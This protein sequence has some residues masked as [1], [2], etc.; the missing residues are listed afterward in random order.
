MKK[1]ILIILFFFIIIQLSYSQTN[2]DSLKLLLNSVNEENKAKILNDIVNEDAEYNTDSCLIY[3]NLALELSEK[4]KIKKEIPEANRQ[5]GRCLIFLQKYDSALIF[6]EKAIDIFKKIDDKEGEANCL[7]NIGR[8]YENKYDYN[9]S[10]N[11]YLEAL[12]IYELLK[13]KESIANVYQDIGYVYIY[14][15]KDELALEYYQKSLDIFTELN[16]QYSISVVLNNIGITYDGI[17]EVDKALEYYNKSIAINQ[18]MGNE[19]VA[20]YIMH[21]IGIIFS[22]K[23]MLDSAYYYFSKSLKITEA[24][25]DPYGMSYNL[26]RIATI[27]KKQGK[28]DSAL[29][30]LDKSLEYTILIDDK[31]AQS[32]NYLEYS[33]IFELKKD[34]VNAFE[35][36]KKY[37]QLKDTIFNSDM[38]KQMNEL[39]TK[40]QTEK[41]ETEN[42]LLK[43]QG[44]K[45]EIFTYFLALVIILVIFIAL[46]FLN[47]KR[48]QQ[49]V[50]K[51]LEIKNFEINQQKE[52][53]QAQAEEL[54]K[55]NVELEKL[56]IVAS[57]TDN[58]VLIMSPNGDLEWINEGFTRLY[59]YNLEEYKLKSGTNL[60][61]ASSNPEINKCL[62]TCLNS[63]SS[64][65]YESQ[66]TSKEGFVIWAQTTITP[67]I[68][69]FGNIQKL[70]AIDSDIRKLKK[71][72]AEIMQKNEEIMTQKEVLEEQNEEI[73]QQNEEI[74][75]QRDELER[76]NV[77][78]ERQNE[79][80]K[81]SIRYAK[82]IQS[83]ILPS[84]SEIMKKYSIFILFKPKDIVSGDF[85]WYISIDKYDFIVVADC[86]GHGVPG[87]FMSMISSR[88]LNEV[89]VESKIF[90]PNEILENIDNKVLKALKK[91]ETDMNDGMDLCLCR[92][93]KKETDYQIVYSGAKRHLLYSKNNKLDVLKS[94]RRSIGGQRK[95][96]NL[97]FTNQELNLSK[98][99]TI[100]LFTDGYADQNDKNRKRFGTER[101]INNIDLIKNYD[102]KE[103]HKI[104]NQQLIEWQNNEEQRDD[105]TILGLQ[106]I[107][108]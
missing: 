6:F 107:N 97:E 33:N 43:E 87:A 27:F 104:L 12:K 40:Y 71:A 86:T 11:Y 59:G 50:N 1:I 105:I 47:G 25:E 62:E 93:E 30:I 95:K 31:S 92:I 68:D 42:L 28:L 36:Y 69:G 38:M 21:N 70:V 61:Q 16:D 26:T 20:A 63:K 37:D 88:L 44:R 55:I 67:I 23:E 94:D 80:I 41:K 4:Y 39:E 83:A 7:R 51:L 34:Y 82:T 2:L 75:A 57:E 17:G 108:D 15:E 32:E 22:G 58:A 77:F 29:I 98:N 60:I 54:E 8:L 9:N 52:E 89:V 100:Y 99:D 79:Q 78:I 106:F 74:S 35:Y 14:S 102:L 91:D 65:I 24:Y 46:I 45:R 96:N 5:I 85:Y 90:E 64:V 19:I 103:Q 13:L 76:T 18:S 56:S 53:I 72:E 66:I 10:L 81:G 3:A 49:K 73:L 84:V 101:L 48:K